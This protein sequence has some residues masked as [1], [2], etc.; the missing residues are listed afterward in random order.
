MKSKGNP[1]I[2]WALVAVLF[3]GRTIQFGSVYRALGY[4]ILEIPLS[5]ILGRVILWFFDKLFIFLTKIVNPDNQSKKIERTLWTTLSLSLVIGF[6]LWLLL[7]N[8]N[9]S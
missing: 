1:L 6:L 9:L 2:F 4:S 5:I 7:S 8:I 3:I